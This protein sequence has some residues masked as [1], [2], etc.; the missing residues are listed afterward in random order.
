MKTLRRNRRHS[1]STL[2]SP[3][4]VRPIVIYTCLSIYNLASALSESGKR[5]SLRTSLC[6]RPSDA[7]TAYQVASSHAYPPEHFLAVMSA[8]A[9]C[10]AATSADLAVGGTTRWGCPPPPPPVTSRIPRRSVAAQVGFV[11]GTFF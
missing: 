9:W 8:S 5:R 3:S 2:H 4:T 10:A 6:L 11:K 7:A 1:F